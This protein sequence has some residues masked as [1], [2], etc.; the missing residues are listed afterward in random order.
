MKTRHAPFYDAGEIRDKA[1]ARRLRGGDER[2]TPARRA[3]SRP[4]R[5]LR[6]G[7]LFVGFGGERREQ[8]LGGLLR[9][10]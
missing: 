7:R 3:P 9:G 5:R 6:A 10:D 4:R 2:H 8:A 1:K